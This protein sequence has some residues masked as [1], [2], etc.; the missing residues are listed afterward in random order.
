MINQ[1]PSISSLA[2]FIHRFQLLQPLE[3]T[4]AVQTHHAAVLIPIICRP[5]PTLLLTRRADFL[6]Q[7]AGQVAFPGGKADPQDGSPIITAL[8]EAAEEVAIPSE[9][10]RILGQL[11]SITSHSGIHVIPIVGLLPSNIQPIANQQEVATIFEIPLQQALMLSRYHRLDIPAGN[12]QRRIYFFWQQQQLI[13]GLT[14]AIIYRLAQQLKISCNRCSASQLPS[15]ST[16]LFSGGDDFSF[17]YP[18]N[19]MVLLRRH[20]GSSRFL[21]CS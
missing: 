20:L 15:A 3:A 16:L 14:A 19:N 10:V 5:T 1:Q 17:G 7:H 6:R 4:P 13:W 9:Q 21:A 12:Q 2:T 11:P 8:R 18:N